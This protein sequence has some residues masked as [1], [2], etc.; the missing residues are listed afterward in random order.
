MKIKVDLPK[1]EIL[2]NLGLGGT[3]NVQKYIASQVKRLCDPYVPMQQGV[4]KNNATIAADGSSI[5]YTQPY[6][7][8][9]YYGKV[10]AGRA[11][12]HYTGDDLTYHGAMRGAEWDKRMLADKSKDL[13]RS[14]D[15]YI[16]RGG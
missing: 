4:L 10:M 1:A 12:K 5:V 8:Y 11:P 9:Q 7:H 15:A 6:A 16:K 3:N 14:V 13:E 2:K